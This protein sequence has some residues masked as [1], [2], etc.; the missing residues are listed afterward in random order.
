MGVASFSMYIPYDIDTRT[1]IQ[2]SV[3]IQPTRTLRHTLSFITLHSFILLHYLSGKISINDDQYWYLVV[4]TETHAWR[5]VTWHIHMHGLTHVQR[6]RIGTWVQTLCEC[7]EYI[8]RNLAKQFKNQ[9]KHI[10]KI[11]YSKELDSFFT[12]CFEGSENIT[13]FWVLINIWPHCF[14]SSFGFE[15]IEDLFRQT[16]YQIMKRKLGTHL[17][18]MFDIIKISSWSNL[19]FAPLTLYCYLTVCWEIIFT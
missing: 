19:Q 17:D 2:S 8:N 3:R 9:I 6:Q 16:L 14:S 11:Q 4:L 10:T 15:K 18:D 12:W 7:S 13:I 1:H 5:F